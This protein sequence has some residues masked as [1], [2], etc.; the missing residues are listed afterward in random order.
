MRNHGPSD[1][2]EEFSESKSD[3][4][5]MSLWRSLSAG[6]GFVFCPTSGRSWRKSLSAFVLLLLSLASIFAFLVQR[7]RVC[8]HLKGCLPCSAELP[9][10][11]VPT[12]GGSQDFDKSLS[13]VAA[14]ESRTTG[15]IAFLAPIGAMTPPR[16][17]PHRASLLF[18]HPDFQRTAATGGG[19]RPV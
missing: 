8:A 19:T 7:S 12:F 17:R 15:A 11:I 2:R 4:H 5:C 6:I 3:P 16:R 14:T 9:S 10:V 13:F 1:G 18:P